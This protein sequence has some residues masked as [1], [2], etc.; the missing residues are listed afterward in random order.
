MTTVCVDMEH[1][2]PI[3]LNDLDAVAALQTRVDRKYLLSA[4][5]L[6]RV[7][8]GLSPAVVILD[9]NGRRSFNYES[10]YFDTPDH[11]SYLGAAL[12]RPQRFKVR[13]RWY[14]DSNLCRLEVKLRDRRG[15]TVKHRIDHELAERRTLTPT[16]IEFL[17][18]FAQV[19]PFAPSLA[20]SLT[21][22]YRRVTLMLDATRMTID[23]DLV[24]TSSEGGSATFG[25]SVIVETKSGLNPS[26][27]DR[28]LWSMRIRPKSLSKFGVGCAVLDP[29]LPSN[30]WRRTA[31][32]YVEVL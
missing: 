28:L 2:V 4:E 5:E 10:T 9:I 11:A 27:F 30:K 22:R 29:T 7:M 3:G 8:E 31:R 12:R 13:T 20:P 17:Q 24:C 18:Q 15:R 26:E 6:D 23:R 14:I 19:A 1:L 16:S 32:E 21:T 25:A